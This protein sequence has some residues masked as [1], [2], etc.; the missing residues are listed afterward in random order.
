VLYGLVK[1]HGMP[2]TKV[3]LHGET[4][5]AEP[6][7]VAR[8]APAARD[9][10]LPAETPRIQRERPL[11]ESRREDSRRYNWRDDWPSGWREGSRRGYWLQRRDGSLVFVNPD[12]DREYRAPPPFFYGRRGWY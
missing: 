9:D 6:P 10:D 11:Y 8:R 7:A 3:V 1:K 5:A 12:R 4:P 2:N